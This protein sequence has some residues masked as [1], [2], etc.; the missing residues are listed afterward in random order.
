MILIADSGSTKVDWVA[1]KEDGSTAAVKTAGINPVFVTREKIVEILE[2]NLLSVTGRDISEVYFYGAGVVS[3]SVTGDLAG[4]FT[5]VFPNAKTYAASDILA[6]ARALCGDNPGIACIMGTG[7]N[8][9][10]YDGANMTGHVN[11]GGFILGDEASGGYF[12]RRFVS[13][14]IKGLL[15]KEMNDEFVARFGL[16]YPK[17]VDKV[18]KQPSPNKFLSAFMPFIGEY[19]ETAYVQDLLKSGFKEFITRNI[20]QYDYKNYALNS[21]GSV[22][23][24]FRKELEEV[25]VECGVKI[26]TIL[27]SPIDGLVNYHREKYLRESGK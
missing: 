8:S 11:A 17:V 7:A 15:P 9:C 26:G 2:E 25:A 1:I 5:Q 16:D 20:Y 22:A 24:I 18:Y 19:R 10:F 12:G 3:D 27:R 4:A 23:Y 13:D 14:F 6:A 21:V